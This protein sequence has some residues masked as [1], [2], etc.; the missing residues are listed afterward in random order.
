MEL[1]DNNIVNLNSF[2]YDDSFVALSK[3]IGR[4]A[5]ERELVFSFN[6]SLTT[7]GSVLF[8]F[9]GDSKVATSVL[10][11]SV[12]TSYFSDIFARGSF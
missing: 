6:I 1:L 12:L 10:D 5:D 3:R 8:D 11:S 9:V 7:E 2:V 4:L